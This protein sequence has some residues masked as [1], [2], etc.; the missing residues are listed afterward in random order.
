MAMDELSWSVL[1]IG[2]PL[3]LLSVPCR[4]TAARVAVVLALAAATVLYLV[5]RWWSWQVHCSASLGWTY[6]VMFLAF[7]LL[8]LGHELLS[9]AYMI[10]CTDRR[11]EASAH[12][13]RLAQE[14]EPPSVDVFIPSYDED[15]ALVERSLK[16]VVALDWRR[17]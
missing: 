10:R 1:I 13:L 16:S 9:S 2:P 12:A 5:W 8:A 6:Q 7:E 4:N 14:P 17:D 15:P 3:L 11:A